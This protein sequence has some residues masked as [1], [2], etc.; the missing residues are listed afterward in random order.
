[1]T[2]YTQSATLEECFTEYTSEDTLDNDN[3]FI[4]SKCSGIGQPLI[5]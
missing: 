2:G 3:K 4:C 1:M 5:T